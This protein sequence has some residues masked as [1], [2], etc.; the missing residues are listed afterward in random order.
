M[1]RFASILGLLFLTPTSLAE[2]ASRV[3]R[4]SIPDFVDGIHSLQIRLRHRDGY[5]HNAYALIPQRDNLVHRVDPDPAAPFEYVYRDGSNPEHDLTSKRLTGTY[6]YWHDEWKAL[7]RDDEE[8]KLLIKPLAEVPPLAWDASTG[9]L[10]GGLEVWI[11]PVGQA[12]HWGLAPPKTSSLGVWLSM[13][14]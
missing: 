9:D 11:L 7:R 12:N 13:R 6:A 2:E 4:V 1:Q 14:A 10:S 3:V 5:F 8:G